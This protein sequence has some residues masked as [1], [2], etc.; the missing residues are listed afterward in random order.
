MRKISSFLRCIT[1]VLLL[2]LFSTAYALDAATTTAPAA[3][4]IPKPLPLAIRAAWGE[5]GAQS[6]WM[7]N[8]QGVIEP[9]TL[10]SAEAQGRPG[11]IP[12]FRFTQWTRQN[13]MPI[14]PVPNQGF[15]LD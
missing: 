8:S 10:W 2:T 4:P 11:E 14:L 12:S 3:A 6:G 15:G 13:L 5:A 1:A 9:F 7:S